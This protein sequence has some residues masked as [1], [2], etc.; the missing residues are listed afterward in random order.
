MCDSAAG[1][2]DVGDHA[3]GNALR[4][5][6]PRP[7]HI[8]AAAGPGVHFGNDSAHLVRADIDTHDYPVV[9]GHTRSG[10]RLP[11]PSPPP[12]PQVL[13]EHDWGVHLTPVLPIIARFSTVC[14]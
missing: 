5:Y 1:L 10:I 6:G 2:D 14:G 3:L 4:G 7:K 8:Q 12:A 13:L 11:E 9:I